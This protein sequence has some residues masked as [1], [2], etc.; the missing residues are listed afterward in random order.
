[1]KEV[2]FGNIL[3]ATMLDH[4]MSPR[5]MAE[6]IG[7]SISLVAKWLQGES[8]PNSVSLAKILLSTS[9]N[10]YEL[11]E[12]ASYSRYC[13]VGEITKAINPKP[14]NFQEVFSNIVA[15]ASIS[16]K[17]NKEQRS[18]LFS[19]F[20]HISNHDQ[21]SILISKAT[22]DASAV[23]ELIIL[24]QP[25]IVA[26]NNFHSLIDKINM[27]HTELYKLDWKKFE[28]LVAHL[29][30]EFGWEIIPMG[31]TKDDGIDLIAIRHVQ[32][33][34]EFSM[35]VQCK[36]YS[37]HRKVGVSVVKDVWATKWEKGFHHAMIATTSKFTKGA[38]KKAE[39]WNFDLRDHESIFE[40]C[41]E[42]GKIV[43]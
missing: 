16:A 38:V 2:Y 18:K 37:Q 19:I 32:P 30:E 26:V 13:K 33:K 43:Q 9:K 23:S 10:H 1:M 39:S 29:L 15:N 40:L 42:Y 3:R 27:D 6:Q 28:D 8:Y 31:Y 11:A 22:E 25:E 34:V 14:Y 12:S 5:L 24:P 21:N 17:L 7:V 41:R 36:R 4:Q 20:E 35:M